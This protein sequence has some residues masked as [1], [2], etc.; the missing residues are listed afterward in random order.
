MGLFGRG[1]EKPAARTAGGSDILRHGEAQPIDAADAAFYGEEIE[2]WMDTAFPG[3][4]TSV[5]HELA[6]PD[7]HV[8]VYVMEPT[9][10]EPYY[11]LYTVGMSALPMTLENIAHP[12]Q[13]GYLRRAEL[14]MYLPAGFPLDQLRGAAG[15]D[16]PEEAYWPVRVLK[17][18][19][20][21]PHQYHTWLGAGHS[22]PNGDPAQPFAGTGFTGV[23]LFLP[24]EGN[25][26]KQVLPVPTKDGGQVMLYLAVPVYPEEMA[27]K[28]RR[29]ADTLEGDLLAL[30]GGRGFMADPARPNTSP[31]EGRP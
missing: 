10:Q 22:V 16:A 19:A 7:I 13:Y 24:D 9:Q 26:P 31:G 30:G 25:G 27:V 6:S 4:S 18:L 2:A 3:R 5:W 8:D 28:L 23:V 14:M 11:V 29:G 21:L 12:D 15:G 1:K 17:S 20:R